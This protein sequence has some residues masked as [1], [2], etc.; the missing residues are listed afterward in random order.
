MLKHYF[1]MSNMQEPIFQEAEEGMAWLEE[2]I[3][4]WKDAKGIKALE[5][6]NAR[7]TLRQQDSQQTVRSYD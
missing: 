7:Q 1:T 4:R 6:I 5:S 2:R 3:E